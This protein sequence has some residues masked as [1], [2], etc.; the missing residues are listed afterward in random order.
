MFD[1]LSATEFRNLA[2]AVQ[3]VLISI[4]V[5]LGGAW[6]VFAFLAQ[7]Y[8][9]LVRRQPLIRLS[10]SI[11]QRTLPDDASLYLYIVVQAK[12][13]GNTVD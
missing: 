9:W 13:D 2:E 11:E 3:A 1:N 6:A 10:L 5:L 4:G 7:R 12:N 8:E